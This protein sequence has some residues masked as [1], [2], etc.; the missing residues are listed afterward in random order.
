MRRHAAVAL[1]A[2]VFA[3]GPQPALACSC[4]PMTKPQ[5]AGF[6]QVVF[7]GVATGVT[8]AFPFSL[9][10]SRSSMDPVFVTFT[11]E[12]VYKGD[13]P[14]ET[15]VSTVV[16]GASCG[17]EFVAGRR[18]TVFAAATEGRF[19]TNLCRGNVEGTIAPSE[20]ALDEGKPPS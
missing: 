18:Y 6:S 9:S 13:V 8:G 12:T 15:T 19:D 17:Y 11:V 7:T 3:L 4:V 14:R 20:Y 2:G 10:C 1:L 5:H 16:G